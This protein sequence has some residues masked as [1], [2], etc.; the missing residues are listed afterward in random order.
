MGT[1]R[2]VAYPTGV[3][4]GVPPDNMK[5]LIAVCA[6][7]ACAHAQVGYSGIVN[8]K[9]PNE[10]FSQAFASKI[11]LIG[12]SAIVTA[13]G[14]HRQLTHAEAMQH[15]AS[16]PVLP[17]LPVARSLPHVSHS[18]I[19]M[20]NGVNRQFTADEAENIAVISASGIVWKD[21]RPNEQFGGRRK[22]RSLPAGVNVPAKFVDCLIGHSGMVCAGPQFSSPFQVQFSASDVVEWGPSGIVYK[23]GRNVQLPHHTRRKRAL[24]AGVA[25]PPKFAKCQVGHSGMV[26]AGA[27]FTKPLL[28]QFR[29]SDVAAFGDSGIVYTDGGNVQFPFHK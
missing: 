24:P 27:G 17:P 15:A 12:P 22:K 1:C 21:G 29:A 19:V 4:I 9:G 11:V 26:C 14:K 16:T 20:P 8:P 6:L 25:V 28:V 2:L 13:D 18:G 7:A 10:Q 3:P 5:L 23:D